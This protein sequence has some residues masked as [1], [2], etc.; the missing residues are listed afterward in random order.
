MKLIALEAS[1]E[2][3]VKESNQNY[4]KFAGSLK[5]QKPRATS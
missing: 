5:R 2:C 4:D 1:A 3:I